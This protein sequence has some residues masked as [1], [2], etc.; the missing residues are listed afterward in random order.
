[1]PNKTI[2]TTHTQYLVML[3]LQSL[4][5]FTVSAVGSCECLVVAF[6]HD[7]Q[8]LA[9]LFSTSMQLSS[10]S[11]RHQLTLATLLSS[12]CLTGSGCCGRWTL[13]AFYQLFDLYFLSSKYKLVVLLVELQ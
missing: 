10:V 13:T 12:L 6:F 11:L 3:F 2:A 8:C 4:Y 5:V 9:V 1:M 7:F